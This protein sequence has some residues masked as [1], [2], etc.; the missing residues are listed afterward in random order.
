MLTL[1]SQTRIQIA[2]AALSAIAAKILASSL[3]PAGFSQWQTLLQ[4]R[5]LALGAATMNGQAAI[6]QGASEPDEHLRAELCGSA[7]LV[8]AFATVTVSPRTNPP[9]PPPPPCR[10]APPPPPPIAK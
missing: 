3:G 5:N 9:A 2:G 8:I 10:A 6:I 1:G 4:V 7:A